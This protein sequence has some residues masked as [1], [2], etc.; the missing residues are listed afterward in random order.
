MGPP[1]KQSRCEDSNKFLPASQ[2]IL[3]AP[4]L[5]PE[6]S[7]VEKTLYSPWVLMNAGVQKSSQL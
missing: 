2:L 3:N 5:D 4:C 1:T 6:Q 7:A